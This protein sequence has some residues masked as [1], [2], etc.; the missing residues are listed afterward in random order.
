MNRQHREAGGI[1]LE[2]HGKQKVKERGHKQYAILAASAG[3]ISAHSWP[4][5]GTLLCIMHL[6]YNGNIE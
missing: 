4:V 2:G 1:S 6:K 5:F 3:V